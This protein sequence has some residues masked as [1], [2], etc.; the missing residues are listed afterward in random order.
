MKYYQLTKTE[1]VL[2]MIIKWFGQQFEQPPV[3]KNVNTMVQMLTFTY[4]YEE[5]KNPTYLPY[6]E[7]WGDWLYHDMPCTKDGGFQHIVFGSQNNQ[8]LWDDTLIMSMLSLAEI[9]L[10]FNKR[11]Y[12]EEAKKQFLIHI[13]YLCDNKTGLWFHGWTF[14]RNHNFAEAI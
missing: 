4:L 8:Q 6:L 12:I 9:G 1:N 14:E 3:E 13:K 11:E 10:L 5:T 2:N 7:T